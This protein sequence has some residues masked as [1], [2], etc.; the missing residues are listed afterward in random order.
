M[1]VIDIANSLA[2]DV[3]Q[4]IIGIRPGEKLHEQMIGIEDAPHTYEYNGFYKI[5]PAIHNWSSDPERIGNGQKVREDFSYTSD[6][7]PEWMTSSEL[8][9]W[10]KSNNDTI[11]RI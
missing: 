5:L 3:K 1:K 11:G 4:K 8:T 9:S 6:N 10:V 7:N 2:P